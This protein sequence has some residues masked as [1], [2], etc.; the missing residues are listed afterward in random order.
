[1]A[2]REHP[3]DR[4]EQLGFTKQ[5]PRRWSGRVAGQHV[6]IQVDHVSPGTRQTGDVWQAEA[7][8]QSKLGDNKTVHIA[9]RSS[10]R[11]AVKAVADWVKSRQTDFE[12]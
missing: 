6:K 10:R 11:A 4:L 1:M 9:D 8:K 2:H 5:M 7:I 12:W 3:A